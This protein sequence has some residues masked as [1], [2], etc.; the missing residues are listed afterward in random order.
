MV[1]TEVLNQFFLEH[2]GYRNA[3]LICC[4]L[5]IDIMTLTSFYFWARHS[6]SWRFLIA[7]AIFYSFRAFTTSLVIF[8]IPEGYNW[9]YPGMMSIFV[10]YGATADFFY[11][12]HVGTCILQMNEHLSESRPIYGIFCL[13]TMFCQAFMMV[14]LRSHYSIDMLAAMIFAHYIFI[15]SER[16]CFVVDQYI[17]GNEKMPQNEIIVNCQNCDV[18]N[19][20][21]ISREI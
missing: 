18:T 21:R 19:Q 20:V 14:A 1:Q 11:S 2:V 5:L 16:Y 15:M 10:P 12:G 9:A 4:S 17:F 6:S 8:E 13:L 7:M 3:M